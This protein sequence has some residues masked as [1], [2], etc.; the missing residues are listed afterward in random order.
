MHCAESRRYSFARA[1]AVERWLLTE[2]HH[3]TVSLDLHAIAQMSVIAEPDDS[4]KQ[5]LLRLEQM[6]VW[7]YRVMLGKMLDEFHSFTECLL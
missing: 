5:T 6:L 4:H 3:R 7:C 1:P 2:L